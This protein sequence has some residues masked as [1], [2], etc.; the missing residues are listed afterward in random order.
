MVPRVAILLCLYHL[1]VI[2]TSSS[3]FLVVTTRYVGREI[4]RLGGCFRSGCFRTVSSH[5]V[6]EMSFCSLNIS[7]IPRAPVETEKRYILEHAR[8]SVDS[9]SEYE[10]VVVGSGPGGGPLAARLA[11]AGHSVLLIDAGD[12]Y[13]N[14]TEQMVPALNGFATEYVPMKW[15]YFVHH[16][17]N[18]TRQQQ[19]SKMV[20]RTA[21]GGKYVGKN[22][23]D[24]AEPLGI[25]YPRAGT[26]GGCGSHNSLVSICK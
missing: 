11:L 4:P 13:G 12:D 20:W 17:A 5:T 3:L 16:Y 24:G 15:D 7:S 26:L 22:P 8:R 25:L 23:P 10:Y 14:T 6:R 21:D 18:T 1:A 2:L 19:D 9:T